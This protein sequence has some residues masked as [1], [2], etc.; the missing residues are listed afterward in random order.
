MIRTHE[1]ALTYSRRTLLAGTLVAATSAQLAKATH[2]SSTPSATPASGG[3]E[4]GTLN[5]KTV[6]QY[7]LGNANGMSVN[8]I[9]YGA[10][11]QSL[12]VPDATGELANVVTGFNT[13]EAYVDFSDYFGAIVGRYANRIAN[14]TFTLDGQDYTLPANNGPN[15]L[16]GGDVGFDK[17]I[18]SASDASDSSVTMT[19][20]SPD[21]EEGYPGNL[22]VAV[23]YTVTDAN[24]LQ[25][26]YHATTDAL[27]VL[28]LS[29]HA[30]FNLAGEGSGSI[31]DHELQINASAFTPVDETLIPTGELTPVAG[32]PFDFMA[33]KPIGQDIRDGSS[34]QL[35]IG[36][37]YDHNFVLD[38]PDE[39]SLIEAAVLADSASGRTMTVSTTQPGIQLYTGNFLTGMF[40]GTSGRVYRQGDALCLETQHFPDSPNQPDF[41]STELGPDDVFES[42]TVYAFGTA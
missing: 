34:Q 21:G 26:D 40:A 33:T 18:W 38:R 27:T 28:N 32:T 24:E 41:P 15:S 25:I 14:R 35:L 23:T 36:Q 16:H 11:I 42:R 1:R 7:T 30:Y 17:R 29:N 13:M 6:E 9:T 8:V 10:A 19:Y 12:S 22:T 4:F 31:Y 20:L 2:M 5:G 39:T 3:S 37:G